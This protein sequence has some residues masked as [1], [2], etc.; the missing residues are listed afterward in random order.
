[1]NDEA[2]RR[3][4]AKYSVAHMSNAKWLELFGAAADSGVVINRA[5]WRFID[6]EHVQ[7]NPLPH[8]AQLLPSRFADGR[9]QPFEYK[10]IL[11]IFIPR[12]YRVKPDVGATRLQ[13][14]TR[15]RAALDAAGNFPLV[16]RGDGLSIVAYE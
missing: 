1:M 5:T 8:R 11:S 12:E 2:Y 10:W 4:R 7:E 14:V 3:A 16:E 9:F 6:T 15:L 13:D